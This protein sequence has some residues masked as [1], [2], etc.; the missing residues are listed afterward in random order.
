M[1]GRPCTCC[2]T[3]HRPEKL[4]WGDDETDPRC[5][6]LK[7]K[8][9]D[10]IESAYDE[11]MRHFICGMARGCDFYFAEAVI[12]LRRQKGDV[13]LEAAVPCPTQANSW[14]ET[15]RARWSSLLA[16]SD[17]ETLVQDHYTNGCML[18]RNRYMVDHSALVIAV[19]DGT[20]GGTRRTLEYALRQKVPF[21]DIPP[22]DET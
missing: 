12:E 17:L 1:R 10:A 4:P 7:R 20:P 2:F 11:G 13:S 8:L 14:S 3:G 5:A 21:V 6:A 9:Y 22:V 15:D 16:Q 18:R 19:Y